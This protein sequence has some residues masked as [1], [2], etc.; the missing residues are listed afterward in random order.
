MFKHTKTRALLTAVLVGGLIAA[1]AAPAS[2][3]VVERFTIEDSGS[4][5][6][7]DFCGAGL[8]VAY[9]YDYTGS[10]TIR[11]RGDRGPLWYHDRFT[12]VETFSYDGMT[13]TAIQPNTLLRD[14]KIV[15]NGDG[16]L[17]VTALLAGGSRLVGSDG[18]L[19]AKD[20][21]QIRLL[22]VIDIATDEV[23]S[24]E[25]IFG[26]TGTNDDFCVAMLEHW[27]V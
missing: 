21:G 17:S 12:L 8:E 19:L 20:D 24:E 1:G 5:V 16:T 9:T 11:T 6:A 7:T 14:H 2:A 4:G 10:S 26:S 25:V 3:R 23:L 22:L 13:V 15:D 18:K 27:G